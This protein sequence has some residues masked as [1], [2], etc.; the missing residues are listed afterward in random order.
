LNVLLIT[1]NDY[2]EGVEYQNSGRE[3]LGV[4]YLLSALRKEG[5]EVVSINYNL[6]N[7]TERNYLD[8]NNFDL[9]GFSLPFWEYRHYYVDYINQFEQL[10]NP[11]IIAGGHAATIGVKYF[12]EKIPNL[13][14]IVMGEGEETLID[15]LK[16]NTFNQ[17]VLGFYSHSGFKPRRL[18]DID[19]LEFPD[20]DELSI[21]L[22]ARKS[23]N[24]A[25][26]CSSRGCTYNCTFCSI[27]SFYRYSHG[28]RWRE[29]SLENVCEEIEELLNKYSSINLLSF[30]DDNF[31]GFSND[32][33][34]RAIS[35]A[36]F[37]KTI[38]SEIEFEIACR[39]DSV[40]PDTFHELSM[41]NLVGVYLGIEA[42]S[43]SILNSF[44]KNTTVK[45]NF[46]AIDTLSSL[47]IGCDIGY[48]MFTAEANFDDV[49]DNFLF[50]KRVIMDYPVFVHPANIFR[51]LRIYPN[52]L[53]IAALNGND[54]DTKK[55]HDNR[56]N[57]LKNAIEILWN[58]NYKTTFL[59]IENICSSKME[60]NSRNI[61]ESREISITLLDIALEMIKDIKRHPNINS[62]TLVQRYSN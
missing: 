16:N 49:Y 35:I 43:Q 2:K 20:R 26:I 21:M 53:G 59:E 18:N 36:Q 46:K 54:L 61:L 10:T 11:K 6:D 39:A 52:D 23:I 47:G 4:E 62:T 13:Y 38:K 50:L 32:H 22:K 9:I 55:S 17:E 14:G 31:L 45:Q 12:L 42:G 60:S 41:Y 19:L 28:K 27:P 34:K 51:S 58:I 1:P 24:E 7:N 3:N 37:I 5:H 29:R 30:T 25:Y 33:H 48:I 15:L 56:I 40:K 8:F 57:Q 44:N